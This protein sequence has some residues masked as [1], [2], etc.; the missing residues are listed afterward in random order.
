GAAGAMDHYTFTLGSKAQL[1]FDVLGP[2]SNDLVWTLIGPAG[3]AVTAKGFAFSDAYGVGTVRNPVV[4]LVP[5]DYQLTVAGVGNATG[6]YAFRLLDLASAPPLTPGTPVVG[7]L[8]PANSTNLYRFPGSA[9]DSFYF[10]VPAQ[11]AGMRNAFW[12]L[13]DPYGNLVFG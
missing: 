2:N 3:A 1:Y 4:G 10:H 8:N 6:T 11:D 13:I 5:G 12:R 7:T 9:G